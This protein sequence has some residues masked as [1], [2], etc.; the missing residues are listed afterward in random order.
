[1]GPLLVDANTVERLHKKTSTS[2][3]LA[4]SNRL[5]SRFYIISLQI[6]LQITIL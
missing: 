2:L 6:V 4:W 1:M 3:G 5:V